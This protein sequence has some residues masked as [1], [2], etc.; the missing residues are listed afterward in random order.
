MARELDALVRREVGIDL[1]AQVL[2]LALEV[3]DLVPRRG[4]LVADLGLEILDLLLE[5]HDR[6]LEIQPGGHAIPFP[7]PTRTN[8]KRSRSAATTPPF[9]A[10]R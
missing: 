1:A 7:H 2:G 10:T 6:L 8:G 3:R 9:S 4:S 5:L